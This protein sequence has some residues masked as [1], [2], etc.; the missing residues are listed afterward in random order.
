MIKTLF[1]YSIVFIL[2]PVISAIGGAPFLLFLT[3]IKK[4]VGEKRTNTKIW[5]W[6]CNLSLIMMC[7]VTGFIMVWIGKLIFAMLGKDSTMLMVIMLGIGCGMNDFYRILI[8]NKA[9][10]LQRTVAFFSHLSGIFIGGLHF[11]LGK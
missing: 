2:A 3:L 6:F 5:F 4:L 7:I 9:N 10:I 8:S 11:L 1:A